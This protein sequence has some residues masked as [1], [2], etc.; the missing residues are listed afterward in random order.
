MKKFLFLAI[1]AVAL[2]SCAYVEKFLPKKAEPQLD[3]LERSSKLDIKKFFNGDLE[4]FAITQDQDGK[5]TG[6][7]T[8]KI[9]GKWDENKGVVQ[10]NFSYDNGKKDSRTWLITLDPDN[11]FDAVG[12]DITAPA[13][14][15]QIGNASQMI[16][17]LL[18][19]DPMGKKEVSFVDKVYLVDDK[20]AIMISDFKRGYGDSGRTIIS[21]KKIN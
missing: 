6:T 3:Y 10:Y 13:K 21:L 20:A 15:K 7:Q 8:I 19:P 16:Y 2:S 12:H 4:G 14:G 11:T 5:I 18:L 9:N 1:T 17:S